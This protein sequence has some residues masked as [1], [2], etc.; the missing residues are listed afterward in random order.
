VYDLSIGQLLR[1]GESTI[2]Y[3]NAITVPVRRT[4]AIFQSI[5]RK[6]RRKALLH[7][8][9][10]PDDA[11]RHLDGVYSLRLASARFAMR[12]DDLL[13]AIIF[14]LLAGGVTGSIFK[15]RTLLLVLS[16]VLVEFAIL[17]FVEGSN[18]VLWAV[19]SLIAVQVGFAAGIYTRGLLEHAG[20]S[21]TRVGKR[22]MF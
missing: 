22:R 20:Y 1:D 13:Y 7:W 10:K 18:A 4:G 9:N 15:V 17:A 21:L 6:I 12:A 2:H 8:G 16:F 14:H 5:C 11:C 3:T 19:A